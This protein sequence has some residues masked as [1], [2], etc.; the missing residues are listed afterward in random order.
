MV[1]LTVT[2]ALTGDDERTRSLA[3][4]RRHLQR[5]NKGAHAQPAGPAG[6]R[7]ITIPETITVA[8]LANRMARRAVD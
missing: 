7:D 4:Y 2:K 6:P 1:S 3:S 5:V 8:E